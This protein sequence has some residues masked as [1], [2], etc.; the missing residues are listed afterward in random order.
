[1]MQELHTK[2]LGKKTKILA[3][4]FANEFETKA[5]E[6]HEKKNRKTKQNTARNLWLFFLLSS[7][8]LADRCL[9]DHNE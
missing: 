9:L 6:K 8:F 4:V 7:F 2:K 1:M 5:A 3:N